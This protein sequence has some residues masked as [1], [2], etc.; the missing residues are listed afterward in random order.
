MEISLGSRSVWVNLDPGSTEVSQVPGTIVVG[1]KS[2]SIRTRK[3]LGW[4]GSLF[5]QELAW[6]LG[7]WELDWC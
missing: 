6:R 3:L 1:P 5:L 4:A 7:S 2:K